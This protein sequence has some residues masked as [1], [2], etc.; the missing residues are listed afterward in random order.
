M[1]EESESDNEMEGR[2]FCQ[3]INYQDKKLASRQINMQNM[4]KQS[5]SKMIG[6]NM[7]KLDGQQS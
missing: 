4:S 3:E 6:K 2:S 5:K 1:T 7:S